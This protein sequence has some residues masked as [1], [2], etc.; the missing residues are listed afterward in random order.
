M[1]TNAKE[2]IAL[3][4]SKGLT[5][6][7]I[8]LL[9][10]DLYNA[11]RVEELLATEEVTLYLAAIET[12]QVIEYL[13]LT[14]PVKAKGTGHQGPKTPMKCVL[15]GKDSHRVSWQT[16]KVNGVDHWHGTL[17][18]PCSKFEGLK[19]RVPYGTKIEPW[20]KFP[21]SRG[22]V[23][24]RWKSEPESDEELSKGEDSK[25]DI[26]TEEDYEKVLDYDCTKDDEDDDGSSVPVETK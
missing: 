8:Q 7:D 17:S 13:K 18:E 20:S 3:M 5:T 14:T 11:V 24:G 16:V 19:F 25:P 2:L 26:P 1:E 15:C 23:N 9:R 6:G 10:P 4:L 22:Q 12:E 21:V